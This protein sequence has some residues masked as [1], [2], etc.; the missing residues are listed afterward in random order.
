MPISVCFK[1]YSRTYANS[2]AIEQGRQ[3]EKARKL[4]EKDAKRSAKEEKRKSK[5]D[6]AKSGVS[7]SGDAEVEAEVT[8]SDATRD[9]TVS[10][11]PTHETYTAP[12]VDTA[13]TAEASTTDLDQAQ[14]DDG[15]NSPTSKV[16]G[17]IKNRFSRRKSVVESNDEKGEK[18]R[19][20][21]R[22]GAALRNDQANASV[23]SLDNRASSMRDV[24][25]AGRNTQHLPRTDSQGVSVDSSDSSEDE[26]PSRD[27]RSLSVMPPRPIEDPAPRS[28]VS[29]S[30]DSRF[31]E[32]ISR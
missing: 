11:P 25:M 15:P 18:R 23:S 14:L 21:F 4:Q 9:E 19:S 30:R 32:E 12:A 20:F 13:N 6:S 5:H 27:R 31:R 3:E 26:G 1:I 28:S 10:Q 24:A 29:P 17:W 8:A 2:L 22:G 16:K 7:G